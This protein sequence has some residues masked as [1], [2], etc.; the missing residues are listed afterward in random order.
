M[1]LLNRVILTSIIFLSS[2]STQT[3]N[4]VKAEDYVQTEDSIKIENLTK[5]E[6]YLQPEEEHLAA[7][8]DWTV[9]I[10]WFPEFNPLYNIFGNNPVAQVET[11]NKYGYTLGIMCS[12]EN[13]GTCVPYVNLSQPCE[14]LEYY[15]A[16]VYD[17]SGVNCVSLECIPITPVYYLFLLPEDHMDYILSGN[18]YGI[19]YGT[20]D[21]LF[22]AAYFSLN[23]STKA[24]LE[25]QRLFNRF[26]PPKTEENKKSEHKDTVL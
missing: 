8:G 5:K 7:F 13:K 21:G 19:A 14:E 6:E 9:N 12:G 11:T 26:Q 23:G 1:N 4:Y 10:V 2:C 25:G 16:L 20:K 17:D 3:G 18:K 24:F 22:R 15:N